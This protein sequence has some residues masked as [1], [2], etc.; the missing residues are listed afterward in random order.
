MDDADAGH[1]AQLL[2]AATAVYEHILER[3]R[4]TGMF[5]DGGLSAAL[6]AKL[7]TIQSLTSLLRRAP[8]KRVTSVLTEEQLT[9]VCA[10][11]A[12]AYYEAPEW[13]A[14]DQQD[15][16]MALLAD[17]PRTG[18]MP[19]VMITSGVLLAALGAAVVFTARR[20]SPWQ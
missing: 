10:E 6:R 8:R 18:A 11:V 14:Q 12:Q 16:L 5:D 13:G 9:L 1:V 17:P 3:V 20:R 19:K 2:D 4:A 7:A 15:V